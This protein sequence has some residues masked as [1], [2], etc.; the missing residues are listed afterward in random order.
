MKA[1]L[2]WKLR[3]IEAEYKLFQLEAQRIVTELQIQR[4]EAY[5]EA[6]LDISKRYVANPTTLD[7]VEVP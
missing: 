3:S 7:F 2:Y 5:L 1:E 6:G 4:A